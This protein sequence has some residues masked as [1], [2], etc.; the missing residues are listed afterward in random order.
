M[1]SGHYVHLFP[2]VAVF[3][4]TPEQLGTCFVGIGKI[5]SDFLQ[6][7]IHCLLLLP[8]FVVGAVVFS[9]C[10]IELLFVSFLVLQ[11]EIVAIIFLSSWL[12]SCGCS[13]RSLP[14]THGAVGW[15]AVCD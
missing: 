14:L 10:F 8:L 4:V 15:S 2:R 3:Y 11:R 9:L 6:L 5:S 12:I 13:Y 1:R 7:L